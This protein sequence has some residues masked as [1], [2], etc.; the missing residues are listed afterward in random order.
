MLNCKYCNSERK[1]KNSLAQ[2]EIRCNDNPNKLLKSDVW[3]QAMKNKIGNFENQYTKAKKEGRIYKISSETSKKLSDAIKNRS[4]EFTKSVGQKVSETIQKK[5]AEG[6]W[7]TSLAKN[8]HY[9][10]NGIDL[11]GTW[12]LKYAQYLDKN[13]IKWI[14]CK[15]QFDYFYDGKNRKYTP[16]FYLIESDEYI[17]IKGYKTEKDKAKWSQFPKNKKLIVLT[18]SELKDIINL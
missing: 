4:S 6:T 8:M 5:V 3:H 17:E 9:N 13:N 11:H 1:N 15:E 14:R 16:D 2:H 18:A 7:H 10:Y 12:E